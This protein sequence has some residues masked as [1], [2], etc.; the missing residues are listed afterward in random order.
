[1][2]PIFQVRKLRHKQVES[3]FPKKYQGTKRNREHIKVSREG[4]SWP[5]ATCPAPQATLGP[6][7]G[8]L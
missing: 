2:N 1:M 7:C 5:K 3:E 8:W 4:R 6:M